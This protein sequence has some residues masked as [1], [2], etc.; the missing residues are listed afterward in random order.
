MKTLVLTAAMVSCLAASS[1]A[2]ISDNLVAYFPFDG[3][4][5]DQ[6]GYG[7]HGAVNGA[8]LCAD[9]FGASGRAYQFDGVNDWIETVNNVGAMLSPSVSVSLWVKQTGPSINWGRFLSAGSPVNSAFKMC[10]NNDYGVTWRV[11]IPGQSIYDTMVTGA[12]PTAVWTHLVGTYDGSVLRLYR[13]G[14]QIVSKS[15]TGTQTTDTDTWAIGGEPGA[16]EG[17]GHNSWFNGCLDDIRVY[18]RSIS[19]SEVMQLYALGNSL[20]SLA[21]SGNSTVSEGDTAAFTCTAQFSGGSTA[22]VSTQS[23]CSW[24]IVGSKPSGTQFAGNTLLAGSV[25]ANTPI[26]IKAIYSSGGETR[27]ATKTVTIQPRFKASILEIGS[28]YNAGTFKWTVNLAASTMGPN[29]SAVSYAWDLDND[30]QRDD[31]TA[32]N[33]ATLFSIGETR[34]ITLAATD[35]AGSIA[36]AKLYIAKGQ[37]PVANEP[38]ATEP[39]VSAMIYSLLNVNAGAFSFDSARKANGLLVIIHGL[40]DSATSGWASEMGQAV[41]A[42][43]GA[44]SPNIVLFDWSNVAADPGSLLGAGIP[45]LGNDPADLIAIRLLGAP[46]GLLLGNWIADHIRSGEIDSNAPIHIIGHSAGGF[47]AGSCACLLPLAITQITML[48]TPLPYAGLPN[49]YLPLGGL[50]EQYKTSYGFGAGSWVSRFPQGMYWTDNYSPYTYPGWN[51]GHNWVHDWYTDQTIS[52]PSFAQNGFYYSPFMNNGFHGHS[53]ASLLARSSPKPLDAGTSLLPISGF[54]VFGTVVNVGEVYTVTESANAGIVKTV[55]LPIGVQNLQFRYQFTSP[56]D[57]D[58]MAVYWGTNEAAFVGLD[59]PISRSNAVD[60]IVSLSDF[61]GQ[62]NTIMFK[63][64]SRSNVNAVVVIDGIGLEI[65]DDPDNDGLTNDQEASLGTDPQ[66]S[67]SDGDGISDGDEVNTYH[68]NPLN[69]DSDND[70]MRDGAEVNSGTSPTNELDRLAIIDIGTIGTTGPT[71]K[72][73]SVTGKSYRVN[74][75]SNLVE[76]SYTTI[77]NTV[78]AISDTNTFTDSTATNGPMFYWIELDE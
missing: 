31:S 45:G 1:L 24:S 33:P 3:N 10:A 14:T 71:I 27:S 57:G 72:W 6:S 46:M 34:L 7:N 17:Q 69:P 61:A 16:H 68:S 65:S 2:G 4:A 15:F 23:A 78:P 73:Q 70:G 44:A 58:F 5:N 51:E 22:D 50:V 12:V 40:T 32:A 67:D 9:R 42:R 30:G 56:G 66:K 76:D 43:L 62:T 39:P 53:P 47:V 49:W 41:N 60:G 19:A 29:G 37:P 52:P 48:D 38:P 25:S 13:N 55:A 20:S 77:T 28:S 75:W 54:S 74:R 11:I 59:L 36:T 35:S 26:T 64:V 63:L 21:I 18:S 8:T